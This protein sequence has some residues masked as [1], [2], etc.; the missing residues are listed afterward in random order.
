MEGTPCKGWGASCEC[1]PAALLLSLLAFACKDVLLPPQA[2]METTSL[3][4]SQEDRASLAHLVVMFTRWVGT[5]FPSHPASRCQHPSC[6]KVLGSPHSWQSCWH[7]HRA[8]GTCGDEPGPGRAP[9][10]WRGLPKSPQQGNTAT[11]ES[12]NE[13]NQMVV[14]FQPYMQSTYNEQR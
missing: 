14:L 4:T 12:S 11:A 7:W 3:K 9:G 13:T 8:P 10:T 6:W 1:F 5:G 2:L